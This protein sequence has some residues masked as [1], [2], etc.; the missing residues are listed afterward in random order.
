[1]AGLLISWIGSISRSHAHGNTHA[2]T[3]TQVGRS[4]CKRTS[5]R[6][7]TA[8]VFVRVDGLTSLTCDKR[9][10][11][12]SRNL[13]CT[14]PLHSPAWP[15]GWLVL[16]IACRHAVLLLLWLRLGLA[17]QGSVHQAHMVAPCTSTMD[18]ACM[19]ACRISGGTR[20][21]PGTIPR[22]APTTPLPG[23]PSSYAASY[24]IYAKYLHAVAAE[25]LVA[26]EMCKR[27]T[28][29][30]SIHPGYYTALASVPSA[31]C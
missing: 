5:S 3:C 15:V 14:Q 11:L 26:F 24:M 13:H 31:V 29:S 7:G 21:G 1:M 22:C 4:L 17:Q 20:H 10:A 27:S 12:D 16:A 8:A 2:C 6:L 23:C 25:P 18:Y 19:H 30:I 9:A 28:Q